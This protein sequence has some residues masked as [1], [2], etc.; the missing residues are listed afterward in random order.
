MNQNTFK[1]ISSSVLS[2][3]EVTRRK[4]VF[5]STREDFVKEF[6]EQIQFLNANDAILKDISYTLY[7]E[8]GTTVEGVTDQNGMTARITSNKPVRI[9][10]ATLQAHTGQHTCCA[11]AGGATSSL[12]V[13]V[14]NVTTNSTALGTSVAQVTTPDGEAR[15][16]TSGE[17]AMAQQVFGSSIDYS[18]VKIHKGEY[19]WFGLQRNNTV[20]APNG[21]VYYNKEMFREDFSVGTVDHVSQLT[22]MHEM[23]HVWQYQLGYPVKGRGAIRVGLS[24]KYTLDA[25]KLLSDYDMEAQGNILADYWALKTLGKFR[26]QIH[27]MKHQGDFALFETVLKN[28]IADP[29]DKRNLP[30]G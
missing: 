21:E 7:L 17:I 10:Q 16:L 11:Q 2:S 20:M 28:F 8:N 13:P 23:T 30:G 24:Y 1:P 25:S 6:D 4:E 14:N 18:K 9:L 15:G 3:K 29:S 12:T 5:I 27:E 19:L 26:P 22:F